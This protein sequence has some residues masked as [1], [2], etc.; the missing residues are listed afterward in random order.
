MSKHVLASNFK[1]WIHMF[2]HP[3]P[4]TEWP[5]R[6]RLINHRIGGKLMLASQPDSS[7]DICEHY[8]HAR[9]EYDS[10]IRWQSSNRFG[11]SV[12]HCQ[13]IQE[14]KRLVDSVSEAIRCDS[15]KSPIRNNSGM[16]SIPKW[17]VIRRIGWNNRHGSFNCLPARRPRIRPSAMS[18]KS[19]S[20]AKW[21]Q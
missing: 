2:Q 17:L 15:T 12:Q 18:T 8:K 4:V 13:A 19:M 6:N 9:C 10:T 11:N 20:S 21:F 5:K 1:R 3:L 7:S 16:R 14:T